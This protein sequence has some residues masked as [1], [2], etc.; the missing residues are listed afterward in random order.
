MK[1]KIIVHIKGGCVYDVVANSAVEVVVLDSDTTDEQSLKIE[2]FV[3]VGFD[4]PDVRN[5]PPAVAK[6]LSAIAENE[7]EFEEGKL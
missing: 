3:R 6:V 4:F 5:D 2:G 1:T 7:K